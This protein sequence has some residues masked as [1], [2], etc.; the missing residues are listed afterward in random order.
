MGG[1]MAFRAWYAIALAA[2]AVFVSLA[3]L[4]PARAEGSYKVHAGDR[5][6]IEV[7]E[8]ESL[9]RNVLVLPD[10]TISF[11]YIGALR[12]AGMT[13]D[14][15]ASVITR[16]IKPQFSIRP[17][18]NVS[19]GGLGRHSTAGA[20]SGRINVYLTGE[21]AKAGKIEVRRGTTL[22][23]VLAEAGGVTKF[24]ADR[25]IELHRHDSA[26]GTDKVYYFS[27][28][29]RPSRRHHDIPLSTELR[30]GDVILVPTKHLFE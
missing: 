4:T 13:T 2:V 18:V 3:S 24:A 6:K 25:R 9:S 15:I 5:L 7:L 11:P 27:M 30:P 14:R 10:G 28:T 17:T 20:G 26:T 12:V 23:Q 1:R 21:I 19:V 29:G 8:D 16:G 22:L